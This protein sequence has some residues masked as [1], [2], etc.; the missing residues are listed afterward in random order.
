MPFEHPPVGHLI[1]KTQ[2]LCIPTL[3]ATS[4]FETDQRSSF[5]FLCVIETQSQRA[6]IAKGSVWLTA[7]A[8]IPKNN[9]T[10]VSV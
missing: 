4:I 3:Q 8:K 7:E 10:T 2:Q 6:L 9:S 1:H 5:R